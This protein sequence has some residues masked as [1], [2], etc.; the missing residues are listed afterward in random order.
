MYTQ[1]QTFTVNSCFTLHMLGQNLESKSQQT[2]EGQAH[3][4]CAYFPF[5]FYGERSA[6]IWGC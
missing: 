6:T 1:A 5:T 3:S 2:Q 4:A